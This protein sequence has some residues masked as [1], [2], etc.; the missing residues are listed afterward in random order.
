MLLEE[1]KPLHDRFV[2]GDLTFKA[3]DFDPATNT[4]YFSVKDSGG[5]EVGKFSASSSDQMET[6][7]Y[8]DSEHEGTLERLRRTGESNTIARNVRRTLESMS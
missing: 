2:A 1:L 6:I 3:E 5:L 8:D 7:D 4:V